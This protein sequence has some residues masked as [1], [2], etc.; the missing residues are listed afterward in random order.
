MYSNEIVKTKDTAEMDGAQGY[1]WEQLV[2]GIVDIPTSNLLFTN[3][4]NDVR[5]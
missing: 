2:S 4:S 1:C 3:L 5:N